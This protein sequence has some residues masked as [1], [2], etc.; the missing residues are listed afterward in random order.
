MAWAQTRPNLGAW[1]DC[2][3][4]SE[5]TPPYWV[6]PIPTTA[7][8]RVAEPTGIRVAKRVR[9]LS[10][11]GAARSATMRMLCHARC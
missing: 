1:L 8:P 4:L 2:E 11:L 10:M 6:L 7:A 9:Y 5:V 3:E